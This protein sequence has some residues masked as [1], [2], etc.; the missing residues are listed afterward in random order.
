MLSD[1]GVENGCLHSKEIID[2]RHFL[3]IATRGCCSNGSQRE[4]RPPNACNWKALYLLSTTVLSITP[5]L[6][7]YLKTLYLSV[8]LEPRMAW[9]VPLLW[10]LPQAVG[11]RPAGPGVRWGPRRG[12]ISPPAVATSRQGTGACKGGDPGGRGRWEPLEESSHLK[13][14]GVS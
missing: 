14:R 2:Y 1:P 3:G 13:N 10:G 9:L 4:R 8:G 11:Q 12:R 7:L 5:K 6:L